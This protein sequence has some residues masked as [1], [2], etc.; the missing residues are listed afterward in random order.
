M[1]LEISLLGLGEDRPG[2]QSVARREGILWDD[3]D[4]TVKQGTFV[5]RVLTERT[6]S[7]F[8]K[9]EQALRTLDVQRRELTPVPA[10]YFETLE[11]LGLA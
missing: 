5:R 10:P 3:L 8:H 2:P 6:V 7:Y 9:K 1:G 4:Q 11:S